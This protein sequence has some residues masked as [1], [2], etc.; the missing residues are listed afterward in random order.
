MQHRTSNTTDDLA[1][2]HVSIAV[3]RSDVAEVATFNKS[4]GVEVLEQK[5]QY[6]AAS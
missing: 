3:V 2:V 1:H 6:S 5:S 4:T